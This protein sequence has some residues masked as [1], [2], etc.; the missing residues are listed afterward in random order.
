MAG[1]YPTDT[2]AAMSERGLRVVDAVVVDAMGGSIEGDSWVIPVAGD[3]EKADAAET[4]VPRRIIEDDDPRWEYDGFV[5]QARNWN[6]SGATLAFGQAS[7]TAQIA[8]RATAV[9]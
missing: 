3:V 4:V 8:F 7:C 1:P 9:Q 5:S 6:A 2:F